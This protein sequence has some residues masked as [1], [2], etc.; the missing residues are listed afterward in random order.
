MLSLLPLVSAKLEN[1]GGLDDPVLGRRLALAC[2]ARSNDGRPANVK[3]ILSYT[4]PIF[5]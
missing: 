2:H 1:V 4:S 5:Y 3:L